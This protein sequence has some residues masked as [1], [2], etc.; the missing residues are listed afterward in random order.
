MNATATKL[1]SENITPAVHLEFVQNQLE[2]LTPAASEQIAEY[3]RALFLHHH[4]VEWEKYRQEVKTH[5]DKVS[6]LESRLNET[7]LGLRGRAKL[8]PVRI[9]GQDDVNPTSPWNSW[10]LAMFVACSLG[11]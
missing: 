5:Q 8:V 4:A 6:F 3:H 9:D 11:I 2:N 7:H 10:D 1:G